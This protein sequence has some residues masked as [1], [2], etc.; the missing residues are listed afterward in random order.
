MARKLSKKCVC[1]VELEFGPETNFYHFV[2]TTQL[3]QV[4]FS[5]AFS[6]HH[7]GN[8]IAL[9]KAAASVN[10]PVV[11]M[12]SKPLVSQV[13]STLSLSGSGKGR[14]SGSFRKKNS[15]N[16][17]CSKKVSF[18]DHFVVFTSGSLTS[19]NQKSPFQ[20]QWS[21]LLTVPAEGWFCLC[22][23]TWR[24]RGEDLWVME[25]L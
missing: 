13:G 18:Q 24:Y 10:S 23:S 6:E 17:G 4:F 14:D 2:G 20:K 21:C 7:S 15:Y 12:T 25:V 19:G 8:Q 16:P 11:P 1:H 9:Q 3:L 22:W 5:A